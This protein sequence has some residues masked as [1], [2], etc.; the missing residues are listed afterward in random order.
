MLALVDTK[1]VLCARNIKVAQIATMSCVGSVEP[2]PCATNGVIG[3][4][5]CALSC[6]NAECCFVDEYGNNSIAAGNITRCANDSN[7]GCRDIEYCSDYVLHVNVST[8]SCRDERIYR[9]DACGHFQL[10]CSSCA[11]VFKV[12][13]A[14]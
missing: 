2:H 1:V 5:Y 6:L 8:D 7:S 4:D 10:L 3:P 14:A 11:I 13:A 12:M 9:P